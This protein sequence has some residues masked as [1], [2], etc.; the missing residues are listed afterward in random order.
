VGLM[1]RMTMSKTPARVSLRTPDGTTL[2]TLGKGANVVVTGDPGELLM[3]ISGRDE[4]KLSFSGD[5][6]AVVAVRGADRGL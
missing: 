5:D 4:A 3:F 1:A 2:A 6:A